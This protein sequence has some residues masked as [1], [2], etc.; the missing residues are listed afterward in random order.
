[1]RVACGGAAEADAPAA[2]CASA[3]AAAAG[4]AAGAAAGGAAGH[5]AAHTAAQDQCIHIARGARS[6][7]C[8]PGFWWVQDMTMHAW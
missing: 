1:M 4:G 2:L 3:A 5:T 6:Y 7:F 8:L